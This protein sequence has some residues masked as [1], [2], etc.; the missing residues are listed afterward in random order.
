MSDML[1]KIQNA[2]NGQQRALS[3][4][5]LLAE[6]LRYEVIDGI[7]SMMAPPTPSHQDVLGE[8]YH[9]LNDYF[10]NKPC[11]AYLA[12]FGLN[13]TKVLAEA[14]DEKT[15]ESLEN[16]REQLLEPDLTVV[17]DPSK[18]DGVY[19]KGVPKLIVEIA[20][21]STAERD[22][23]RKKEIYEKIGVNEYWFVL[24]HHNIYVYLLKDGKYE[25]T[26]YTIDKGSL[27]LPVASF[28]DLQITLDEKEITKFAQWYN[29]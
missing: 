17:C 13:P 12:P 25:Q 7:I 14:G 26:F 27:T 21:P 15:I 1:E 2:R 19:Y 8:I 3:E 4:E 11:K 23:G 9:K 10:R 22:D 18:F 5:E 6:D 29:D 28:P 16:K 20:S 24:D